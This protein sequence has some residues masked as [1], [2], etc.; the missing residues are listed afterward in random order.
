MRASFFCCFFFV[1]TVTSSAGARALEQAL[2]CRPARN[3]LQVPGPTVGGPQERGQERPHVKGLGCPHHPEVSKMPPYIFSL[4]VNSIVVFLSYHILY[5]EGP[6]FK[7]LVTV[8]V[9]QIKGTYFIVLFTADPRGD[10]TRGHR[11]FIRPAASVLI[12]H[13]VNIHV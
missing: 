12:L 2:V 13:P 6:F 4:D 8:L 10:I 9:L 11:R 5:I 1:R 3:V 7:G